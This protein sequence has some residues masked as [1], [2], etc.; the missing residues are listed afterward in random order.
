MRPGYLHFNLGSVRCR[1]CPQPWS[2]SPKGRLTRT[3]NEQ[4]RVRPETTGPISGRNPDNK[5]ER[6]GA[7]HCQ[8]GARLAFVRRAWS[9]K[10]QA[11]L[12]PRGNHTPRNLTFHHADH[13]HYYLAQRYDANDVMTSAGK[14]SG[15]PKLCYLM[16]PPDRMFTC[17]G[18]LVL[19]CTNIWCLLPRWNGS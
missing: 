5:W 9:W 13:P 11:C 8:L 17:R 2:K 19:E 15:S 7:Q 3:I 16:F 6:P 10:Y 4:N 12:Q 18:A 1:H 14:D